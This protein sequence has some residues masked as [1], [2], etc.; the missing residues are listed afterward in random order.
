[1]IR[2]SFDASKPFSLHE[3]AMD[4][5]RLDLVV[6]G[7]PR[8]VAE[9]VD[10]RDFDFVL[11][12]QK[13]LNNAYIADMTKYATSQETT[14]SMAAWA[15][16]PAQLAKENHKF[17]YKVIRSG[18]RAFEYETP[19][20]WLKSAGIVH[21]CVRVTE[22]KEPLAVYADNDSFKVYMMDT[23]LLC[24]KFDLAANVVISGTPNFDGFKGALTENYI[25]QALV[26]NGFTPFYWRSPFC[27][28]K[29]NQRTT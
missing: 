7:M 4:L 12:A 9:F 16:V 15:S 13:T 14:R 23:G 26:A 29:R 10:T 21:K 19:L 8:A 25:M 5:Y 3:T 11:S 20:D 24:S 22:G 28:S 18:A 27:L 1:L 17:Q 6:G 2:E